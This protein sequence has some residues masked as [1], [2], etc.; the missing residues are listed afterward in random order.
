MPGPVHTSSLVLQVGLTLTLQM[1][2]QRFREGLCLVQGCPAMVAEPGP[3][4]EGPG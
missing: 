2:K 1:R 4:P 3:D